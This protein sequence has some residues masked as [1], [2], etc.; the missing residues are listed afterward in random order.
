MHFL[1][2]ERML[3]YFPRS[4][5]PSRV[6]NKQ[7]RY[8]IPGHVRDHNARTRLRLAYLASDDVVKDVAAS[9]LLGKFQVNVCQL[10]VI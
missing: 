10:P 8:E 3:A 9:S 5:T 4:I 6:H 2:I 7:S 1:G